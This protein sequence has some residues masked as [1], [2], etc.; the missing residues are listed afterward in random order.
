MDVSRATVPA[1]MRGLVALGVILAAAAALAAPRVPAP[2]FDPG[3][4]QDVPTAVAR[5]SP[6]V[7]GIRA[8]I[9]P[10]RP[11]AATLG[12]ERWGSGVIVD[13][14]GTVLTVGYLVLEATA[15]EVVLRDGRTVA[16]RVLGHDFESGLAVIMLGGGGPYPA[17]AL[18]RSDPVGPGHPVSVVGMNEERRLV[19]RM[20]A[21][22]AVRRFVAYWEYLLERALW[23]AP[24]HPAF[25]G[26]VLVD[27]DGAVIG[28]VSLRLE[29]ENLAIPIDLF[30]PVR[31]ALVSQGRPA[32]PARP[33]L[34]LRAVAVDGGVGIAGV[35]P[36]GPAHAAGLRHGDVIVRLNGDRVGDLEDFYRKLWRT[37]VGSELE[38]TVYR[39]GQLETV[40]LRSRDRYGVF[41]FRMP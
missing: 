5:V 7:V 12:A 29:R 18:G 1:G 32:R 33:W 38:L 26:A 37:G 31:E 8:Q 19:A 27:S 6:A 20:A 35:S 21:V 17:V 11:S 30:P 36:A 39:G 9:P 15:L 14:D 2:R 40:T 4:A 28:L 41:Q 23:V 16:A 25:G 13:P 34:G 10:D 24:Q 22:T 3:A